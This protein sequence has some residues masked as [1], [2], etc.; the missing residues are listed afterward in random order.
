M[1]ASQFFKKNHE[2]YNLIQEGITAR[3]QSISEAFD[4]K[5]NVIFLLAGIDGE[6]PGRSDT[7][8]L[9]NFDTTTYQTR[10]LSLPRDTWVK[11]ADEEN[12]W[13][14]LTH[15]YARGEVKHNKE[16]IELKKV[17]PE[18]DPET[19]ITPDNGISYLMNTIEL[20]FDHQITIDHY[21]AVK[22]EGF[23][24]IVDSLGGC[25]I[26]VE[27]RMKYSDRSQNLKIDL[28]PGLQHLDGKNTLCYARFRH[29]AIGDLGRMERQQRVLSALA[30]Q[31]KNPANIPSW[32]QIYRI[33]MENTKTDL[34]I[35][36]LKALSVLAGKYDPDTMLKAF[37]MDSTPD[38]LRN[39][40]SIQRVSDE[41][42]A[43]ALEFLLNLSPDATIPRTNTHGIIAKEL[44]EYELLHP[45]L[46]AERYANQDNQTNENTTKEPAPNGSNN[47]ET[48]K[49]ISLNRNNYSSKNKSGINKSVVKTYQR[50]TTSTARNVKLNKT[51]SLIEKPRS[52]PTTTVSGKIPSQPP[53]HHGEGIPVKSRTEGE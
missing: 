18:I 42:K 38:S 51:K 33:I 39:G 35:Q 25:E 5:E 13:D 37:T 19:A 50:T 49:T 43:Q 4:N 41:Q 46:E 28:Q 27:K 2:G 45:E 1:Y 26:N 30:K 7:V 17:N 20:F 3:R 34:T 36:Q 40:L 52:K 8:I 15:S 31:I 10:M 16:L 44:G 21:I 11:I 47:N 6:P 14:K 9:V 32:M 29:D 48:N 12:T 53:A 22:F 24:K 23:E